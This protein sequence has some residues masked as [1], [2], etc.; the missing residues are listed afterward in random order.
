MTDKGKIHIK[1]ESKDMEWGE[2]Q[3]RNEF[4]GRQEFLNL[5]QLFSFSV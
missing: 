2:K 3:E 1:T 5:D 4:F